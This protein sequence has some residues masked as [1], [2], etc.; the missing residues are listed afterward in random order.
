MNG[1]YKYRK[2]SMLT[3][4]YAKG[5]LYNKKM[6]SRKNKNYKKKQ[7]IKKHKK[8]QKGGKLGYSNL[9][10]NNRIPIS[11]ILNN[12]AYSN[13]YG[14]DINDSTYYGALANP[15]PI[16]AYAKCPY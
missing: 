2:N 1:G 8:Y 10:D 15:L 7:S 11:Y 3:K 6:Y 14:I 12:K 9:D 13:G 5:A 4:K 16:T